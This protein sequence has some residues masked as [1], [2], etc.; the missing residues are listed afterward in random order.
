MQNDYKKPGLG[1]SLIPLLFLIVLLALNIYLFKDGATSGPNQLALLA[2]ASLAAIIGLT[3][4][5]IDYKTMEEKVI[6]SIGLSMQ[7]VLI[8][9]VVGML[10]GLWILSGVVPSMIYYGIQIVNPSW[11][12]PI[13]CIICA[14]V[15]L[16]TGSSWSTGGTVGIALMGI[17]KAIG[18]PEEMVAGAIISGAYF[19]DKLS[20]LSDT[21][22]LAPAMAGTD[23]FTHVRYMLYTTVPSMIIALILFTIVGLNYSSQTLDMSSVEEITTALKSNFWISPVAFLLP[24]FVIILVAK[25][26]PAL[27]ALFLGAIAGA[28]LALFTQQDLY[29]RLSGEAFTFLGAWKKTIEIGYGGFK[30]ETGVATMDSLLSRGGMSSMLN[31]VWLIMMA[32][33]FGGVMEMS[34]MLGKIAETILKLVTGTASLITATIASCITI[35]ITAADQYLAIVVPGR[36]FRNAYEKADLAPENLS[37][38]LEDAGTL[39]S[40]LVPWNTCGAYFSGVLGIATLSYLP[41]CFF[42]LVNPIVAIVIA[43]IGYK[44]RKR[45]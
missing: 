26:V 21:T 2:A 5:K 44:I 43:T 36:M 9:L 23:L 29:S 20:P 14:V 13:T 37:R 30:I 34:G 24:A 19:G 28:F 38:S 31:T 7:A 39:T 22:N 40:V 45:S 16:A 18:M 1:L 33:M 4:L 35:N 32:M 6:H 11:F 42:N 17:G 10:I 27:P 8:L 25:K 12:L 41:Y 3:V 15:S